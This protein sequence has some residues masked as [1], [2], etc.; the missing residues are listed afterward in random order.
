MTP[1]YD[2]LCLVAELKEEEERL[3]SVRESER[4]IDWC[5]CTLSTPK[6]VQL[7]SEK[8]CPSRHQVDGANRVDGR[9]WKQVPGQ[10]EQVGSDEINK[11]DTLAIKKGFKALGQLVDGTGAQ[12]VF[13][14][15]PAVAG[16]KGEGAV[17][18]LCREEPKGGKPGLRVISAAQL[19]CMY[20]SAHSM[21]NKKEELEAIVQKE[22]Y[23]VIAITETWW[24]AS[25]DWNAAMDGYTIF[26][27]DRQGEKV[28][29]DMCISKIILRRGTKMPK[30]LEDMTYEE[31]MS[32]FCLFSSEKR[33]LKG[34]L[35]TVYNLFMK[36]A[37]RLPLVGAGFG[38]SDP[39]G[40]LPTQDALGI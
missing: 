14:S 23:D 25:H 12:V 11:R 24:D 5:S 33:R 1:T 29:I 3:R 18:R 38:V 34:D 6:E 8:P 2:L 26:R 30:G 10:R 9:E 32:I 4:E 20:T 31:Q 39:H 15:I 27:R 22:S 16:L 35:I 21:G 40:S 13:T 36:G 17:T 28:T 7:E 37:E 19:K